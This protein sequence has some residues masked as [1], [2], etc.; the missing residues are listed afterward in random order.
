MHDLPNFSRQKATVIL[1]SLALKLWHGYGPAAGLMLISN[2][3]HT[4]DLRV[5]TVKFS[6]SVPSNPR[7]YGLDIVKNAEDSSSKPA[8]V[9]LSSVPSGG[10]SNQYITRWIFSVVASDD[11]WLIDQMFLVTMQYRS[12]VLI[13]LTSMGIVRMVIADLPQAKIVI[14]VLVPTSLRSCLDKEDRPP[15][16]KYG[17]TASMNTVN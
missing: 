9:F 1:V 11:A 4:I 10:N 13:R 16:R 12:S 17:T 15:K 8:T 5:V 3:N 7:M 6:I 14:S 2:S